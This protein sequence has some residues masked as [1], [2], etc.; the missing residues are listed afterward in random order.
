MI[1]INLSR[2][3]GE[4]KMKISDLAAAT[5]L[6]RNGLSRLYYDET[7]GIKFDTLN[8]LCAALNCSVE[9]LLEYV[10]DAV[11]KEE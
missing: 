4:R 5:N 11:E 6:N 1:K 7:D 9:E 10:P 2:L 3:M 8:K